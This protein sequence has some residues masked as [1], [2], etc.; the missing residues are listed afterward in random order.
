MKHVTRH[1]VTELR[2]ALA[3]EEP[4]LIGQASSFSYFAYGKGM[5]PQRAETFELV[6]DPMLKVGNFFIIHKNNESNL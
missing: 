4:T 1:I 3:A 5:K 2:N 6:D